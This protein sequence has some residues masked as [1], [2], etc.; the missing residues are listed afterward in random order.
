[1]SHELSRRQVLIGAVGSASAMAL[2]VRNEGLP[3]VDDRMRTDRQ[4]ARFLAEQ[5]LVWARMPR[6]WYDGPAAVALKLTGWLADPSYG[7]TVALRTTEI[8]TRTGALGVQ[9]AVFHQTLPLDAT[10]ELRSITLP[11]PTASR[12]H[13]FALSLER[14]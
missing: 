14:A 2:P 10:R 5:D 3:F 1:M 8:H 11:Q 13:I 12:P 9:A 7:E 6:T 4:W